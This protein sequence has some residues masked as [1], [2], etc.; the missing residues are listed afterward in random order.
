MIDLI[1]PV[2]KNL[3]GLRQTLD[4][5]NYKVFKVTAIED[6]TNEVHGVQR[7]IDILRLKKNVGPGQAR[8]YGID[9]TSNPYIMFIDAGDVFISKEIQQEIADTI[10]ANPYINIFFWLY[11]YKDK[12]TDHTDNRLHGK[13]YKRKFL[14]KYDIAF[15]RA[16]SYMNE[17]IG[18]NRTCRIIS[19]SI[20][21]SFLYIDKPVIQWVQEENSL[22]QKNNNQSL[23]E[24][25]TEALSINSIHCIS[26]C[27]KNK[28]H[29][30]LIQAEINEIA[31]ALYY[32]F[33]RTAAERPEFLSQAWR[34][35]RIFYNRFSKDINPSEL[36]VGS[37]RMTACML[38][39]K[40]IGFPI[41]ILRFKRDM[42]TFKEIPSNYLTK[43]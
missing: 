35:A 3:K 17:D 31:M 33:I 20:S 37:R 16:G 23:Y 21:Q 9:N 25:Q 32:W 5:I 34:G 43:V 28:I 8:Q 42:D 18:F 1:I 10:A 12:L 27:R 41:N 22:T 36:I 40:E 7:S 15:S 6:G 29:E 14:N 38:Y 24:K 11:Y 26:C 4:S 2:Y 30:S 13:V 19:N 39:R